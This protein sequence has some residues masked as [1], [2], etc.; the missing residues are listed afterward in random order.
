MILIDKGLR[1]ALI[2]PAVLPHNQY[3]IEF[4]WGGI[5]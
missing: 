5:S 1:L 3:S 4:W 2:G